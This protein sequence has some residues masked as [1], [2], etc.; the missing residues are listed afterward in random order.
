M[1]L[2]ATSRRRS[3]P[4]ATS[5][6][7]SAKRSRRGAARSRMSRCRGCGRG[8]P[9]AA[10]RPAV[11]ATPPPAGA[12]PARNRRLILSAPTAST[13][14]HHLGRRRRA[15]AGTRGSGA[16][17][18]RSRSSAG[19]RPA[20]A[21][22]TVGP[23]RAEALG[24][25]DHLG[26]LVI[27]ADRTAG[28]LHMRT[29]V[30]RQGVFGEQGLQIKPQRPVRAHLLGDGEHRVGAAASCRGRVDPAVGV[31]AGGFEDQICRAS[32]K[33]ARVVVVPRHVAAVEARGS[34]HRRAAGAGRGASTSSLSPQPRT[35][36]WR[37]AS[38]AE[39][40]D[41]VLVVA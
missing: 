8:S 17:R 37:E 41:V 26:Q 4:R 39:R 21:A 24:R 33:R 40:G 15:R 11:F 13:L 20:P 38:G 14:V 32:W 36:I 5:P 31:E 9:E 10:R 29:V 22:L 35:S 7:R 16:A 3:G 1:P 23:R 34:T 30:H 27:R 12:R 28:N 2:V 18:S 19:R 25:L 6:R